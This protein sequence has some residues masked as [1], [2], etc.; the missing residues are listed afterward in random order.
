[1]G[2]RAATCSDHDM[3][4]HKPL[5]KNARELD[6]FEISTL[7]VKAYTESDCKQVFYSNLDFRVPGTIELLEHA[8]LNWEKK[9]ILRHRKSSS[10]DRW[11]RETSSLIYR[12]IEE[13]SQL[14]SNANEPAV[15]EGAELDRCL[16]V[17]L[18]TPVLSV[19]A[20][21]MLANGIQYPVHR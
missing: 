12:Q 3:K 11:P 15:L 8:Q 10:E 19:L 9:Q 5:I 18:Y 6:L 20:M 13:I 14:Y 17:N 2:Y 21:H 7:S 1:L 4:K 16:V